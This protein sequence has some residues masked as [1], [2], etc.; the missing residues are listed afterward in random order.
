MLIA[1]SQSNR[2]KHLYTNS[3]GDTK[4]GYG[5]GGGVSLYINTNGSVHVSFIDCTR[6]HRQRSIHWRRLSINVRGQ[7]NYN[8]ENIIV[9]IV[10]SLSSQHRTACVY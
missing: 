7:K 10:D 9:Q 6:I 3:F 2:Y 1:A 5:R 4:E 8:K